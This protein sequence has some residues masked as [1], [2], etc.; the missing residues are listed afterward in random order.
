L[1]SEL[2]K[3]AWVG[4]GAVDNVTVCVRRRTCRRVAHVRVCS[5]D[6]VCVCCECLWSCGLRVYVVA[7]LGKRAEP[8]G[9]AMFAC[10]INPFLD[11]RADKGLP[12]HTDGYRS[13]KV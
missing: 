1:A 10:K 5:C 11:N 13:L 3:V 6:T 4:A 2:G 8:S 7:F 12:G 9:S